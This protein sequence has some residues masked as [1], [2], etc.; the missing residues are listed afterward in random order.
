[1]TK[2][3]TNKLVDLL[4]RSNLVDEAKLTAFLEKG[5]GA[6]MARPRSRTRIGWPS[7]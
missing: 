2:V 6:R 7:C 1:M 3:T 5:R 4:R